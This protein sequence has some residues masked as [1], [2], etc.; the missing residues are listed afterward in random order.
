MAVAN[1]L[2]PWVVA[3]GAAAGLAASLA[4]D[5]FLIEPAL[6][7]VTHH[8]LPIPDLP[9]AWEGSRVVHLSDLH[10][11]DPRSEKLFRWMVRT[12]NE[13]EPD[14]VVIT[15]DHILGSSWQVPPCARYLAEI[16]SRHGILSVLGDHDFARRRR[17]PREGVVEGLAAAGV[18]LLRNE[19]VELDGGLRVAGMDPNTRWV[20]QGDLAA[21]LHG[22]EETGP[23]LLLSHSPEVIPSAA[24]RG[25]SMIL[26]GHTHGGQVVV[27]FYGPPITMIRLHRRYASG[28]SALNATRMYTCRGLA[29]HKSLRFL[30][31]PEVAVFRLVSA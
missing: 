27:P 22:L 23:H 18:T 25:V 24:A 13:L 29:S 1:T 7:E 6:V 17:V 19:W 21:T 20:Q 9:T 15:G 30:C 28:W 14:L 5:A 4:V 8:D 11:G 26:A 16:R 2:K 31:R 10:Y 12:V 3:V